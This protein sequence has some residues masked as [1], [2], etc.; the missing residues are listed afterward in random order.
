MTDGAQC[1]KSKKEKRI[2]Q[3]KAM[4]DKEKVLKILSDY[5]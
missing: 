4:A 2:Q 5:A 1:R 3:K